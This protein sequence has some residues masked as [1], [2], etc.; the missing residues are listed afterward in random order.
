ME[1]RKTESRQEPHR[2][3]DPDVVR[4]EMNNRGDRTQRGKSCKGADVT[5]PF[6]QQRRTG[7]QARAPR[8]EQ[9]CIRPVADGDMPMATPR[10]LSNVTSNP[11]AII[12]MSMPTRSAQF[13]LVARIIFEAL[14]I[15]LFREVPDIANREIFQRA[16]CI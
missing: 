10:T 8:G 12:S 7:A 5:Y 9:A 15:K 2:A 14:G 11:F 6:N 16:C 4:D 13:S 1:T 3:P